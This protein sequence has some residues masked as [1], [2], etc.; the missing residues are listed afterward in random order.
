[1]N[2]C[3]ARPLPAC[4]PPLITLKAGT[5]STCNSTRCQRASASEALPRHCSRC[6]VHT[7]HP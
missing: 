5:G 2:S 1:M 3:M 4:S 6:C 7:L